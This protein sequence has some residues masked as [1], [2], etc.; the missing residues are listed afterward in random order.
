GINYQLAADL[1][2]RCIEWHTVGL[3]MLLHAGQSFVGVLVVAKGF[4]LLVERL[5]LAEAVADV[6]EVAQGAREMTFE[7]IGVQ[8]LHLAAA[9]GLEEIAEVIAAAAEFLDHLTVR[10]ERHGPFGGT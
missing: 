2:G 9:D 10:V 4:A 6:A 3:E 7:D 5:R 8:L 1:L